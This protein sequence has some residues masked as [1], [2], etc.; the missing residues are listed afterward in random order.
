MRKV[1][2]EGLS[3]RED[4]TRCEKFSYGSAGYK[5][6]ATMRA[7]KILS[8]IA[9]LLTTLHL[10]HAMHHL[11]FVMSLPAVPAPR[12]SYFRERPRVGCDGF[13]DGP[14]INELAFA[15]A[16]DQPGFAQ[17]F[18]MVRDGCG[19]H[20]AHRDD[21]ATVHVV[22]CRDGFEDPEASLVC[23]GL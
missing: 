9:V 2:H 21:L 14:A 1:A 8:G 20:A 15:T 16:G 23:Q 19:G 11:L 4:P 17:N 6:G 18:E 22:G 10:A 13:G 3:L 5:A 12:P 7:L